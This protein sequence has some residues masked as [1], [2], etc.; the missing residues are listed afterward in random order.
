MD[1]KKILRSLDII[2]EELEEIY[3][4]ENYDINHDLTKTAKLHSSFI[5]RRIEE[6]IKEQEK[7]PLRD[8][9]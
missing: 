8:N 3:S 2:D 1:Y 6:M 4:Q 7:P 5:R 9:G